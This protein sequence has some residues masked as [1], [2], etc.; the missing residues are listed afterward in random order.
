MNK[1]HMKTTAVIAAFAV[2][3]TLLCVDGMSQGNSKKERKWAETAPLPPSPHLAQNAAFQR[4]PE[5]NRDELLTFANKYFPHEMLAAKKAAE[6]NANN[7]ADMMS[8]VMAESLDLM[9]LRRHSKA[10][11]EITMKERA[12]NRV[13]RQQAKV[14][15]TDKDGAE[16]TNALKE[17]LEDAFDVKQELLKRDI[18]G[19]AKDLAKLRVLVG[20]RDESREVIVAKRLNELMGEGE[21]LRW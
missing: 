9:D 5:A 16:T 18:E 21:H 12:L 15:R 17:T 14:A 3:M 1:Q 2:A 6:W 13:A 4:F 8:E 19:M 7:A 11:F 20:K 10:L